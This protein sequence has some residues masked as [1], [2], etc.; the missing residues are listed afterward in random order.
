[1]GRADRSK[2]PLDIPRDGATTSAARGSRCFD[3][4]AHLYDATRRLPVSVEKRLRDQL[5]DALRATGGE[6]VLEI[7][8]GTGRIGL[9]LAGSGVAVTGIDLAPRMLLRLRAKAAARRRQGKSVGPLRLL[10]GDA[11]RLP[12]RSRQFDLCLGVH[13]LHLV[14]EPERSLDEVRRVL[15]RGGVL[16]YAGEEHASAQGGTRV[17][18]RWRE[19]L[20]ERGLTVDR[21]RNLLPLLAAARWQVQ[22]LP[23]VEWVSRVPVRQSLEMVRTRA[24]SSAWDVPEPLHRVVCE[25][26]ERWASDELGLDAIEPV[27]RRFQFFSARPPD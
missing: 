2:T 21:R 26:L 18:A 3:R 19:L 25:L 9:L 16:L 13:L 5:L 22:P 20:S 8:I 23:P 14:P 4:V 12:L 7:G 10:V 6:A 17:R 11:A 27:S 24:F 1:M 15:R